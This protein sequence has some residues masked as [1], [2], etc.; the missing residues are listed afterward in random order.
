VTVPVGGKKKIHPAWWIAGV[1]L[2]A[3][4]AYLA[5]QPAH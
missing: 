2:L 1:V 5:F 4:L 3:L